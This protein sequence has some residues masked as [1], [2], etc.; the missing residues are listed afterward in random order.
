MDPK[1]VHK[2]A[3]RTHMG[4]YEYLVM[5]FGLV[6]APSTF[7][8]LMNLI[9]EP[10][11]RKFVLVFFDDILIYSCSEMEHVEHLIKVFQ[12][13][14]DQSLT[15]KLSKCSFA[16][17]HVQYLGHIISV[18]GVATDPEKVKAISDWPIP[19]T[20]KQLRGF[21][22]LAGYY[23][24]FI[25]NY[26]MICQPL[27]DLLKKN[28]VFEWNELAL[29]AF[30]SLKKVLIT[31]PVLALPN[32]DKEFTVETNA[33]SGGIGA[34]LLQQGHPI[35][36]ISKVLSKKH[37]S[38]SVYDKQLFAVLFAVKKWHQFLVGRHFVIKTD[39]KPLKF[40]I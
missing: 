24:R 39:H 31:A 37:Q 40:L 35:A 16:I 38:L 14:S 17:K 6:N 23:R 27:N 26:A 19:T 28:A 13:L 34:V 2:T 25:R 3:F 7:Q 32:F 10:Y 21:L 20:L 5:P 29:I 1:D 12:L 4:H 18:E 22:G 9:F 33:S 15:V 36:F 30:N 8:H 11:L